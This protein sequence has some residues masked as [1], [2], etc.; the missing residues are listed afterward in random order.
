VCG[1]LFPLLEDE[2]SD[3]FAEFESDD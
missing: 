3:V 2:R 1:Y